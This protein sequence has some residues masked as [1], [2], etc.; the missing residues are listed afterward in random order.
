MKKQFSILTVA[1]ALLMGITSCSKDN[2]SVPTGEGTL[3]VNFNFETVTPTRAATSD[4][5]PDTKWS[6]IKNLQLVLV[7][8]TG[9]AKVVRDVTIPADGAATSPSQTFD[10]IPTG[11]YT[12]YLIANNG[13]VGNPFGST[14]AK[15]G[16]ANPIVVGTNFNTALMNLVAAPVNSYLGTAPAN[17]YDEASELFVGYAPT[18]AIEADK[19]NATPVDVKLTRA[20]SLL[21]IRIDQT[22]VVSK[23]NTVDFTHAADASIRL[24]RHAKALKILGSPVSQFD[25]SKD[26]QAFTSTK[27]FKKVAPTTGYTGNM[28]LG[29]DF[30]L[31]NDY[32]ILPGGHASVGANKFNLLISGHAPAGYIN[33]EGG[34]VATGGARVWWQGDVDG[35]IAANGILVL[36]VKVATPGYEDENPP[37]FETYGKLAI[38][39]TIVDWAPATN[40]NVPL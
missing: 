13:Y 31:W 6:N 35:L 5:K 30:T 29:S 40:V 11:S 12:I 2:E 23:A 17:A 9:V 18:G 8:G 38:T 15:I 27:A 36:N 24:R 1:V 7:D 26:G 19:V 22:D 20:V 25:A 21:R 32:V 33:S 28:G 37:V 34:I 39:A 3:K 10:R 16:T 4:A 14:T